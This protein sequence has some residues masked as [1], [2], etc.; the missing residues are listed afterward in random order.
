MGPAPP[1]PT[2]LPTASDQFGRSAVVAMWAFYN[3]DLC[4]RLAPDYKW[5]YSDAAQSAVVDALSK[6]SFVVLKGECVRS[7]F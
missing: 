3:S 1:I 7:R 5:P 4:K 2:N 6:S